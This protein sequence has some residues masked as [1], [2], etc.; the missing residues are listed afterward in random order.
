[1]LDETISHEEYL[2]EINTAKI[3]ILPYDDSN[4]LWTGSGIMADCVSSLTHII[5]P[6]GTAIGNEIEL[7][8]LGLTY[9]DI[10]EIP[11]LVE[12]IN[13]RPPTFQCFL[14]YNESSKDQTIKWLSWP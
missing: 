14:D 9:S 7:F 5:A 4:Y 1:V 10:S 2:Y 13:K 6:S 11:N 3:A 12:E 8:H